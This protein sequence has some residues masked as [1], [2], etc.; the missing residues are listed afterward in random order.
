MYLIISDIFK[1]DNHTQKTYFV[2]YPPNTNAD[3]MHPLEATAII[4]ML[5]LGWHVASYFRNIPYNAS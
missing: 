5:L 3:S 1:S 2:P 4:L